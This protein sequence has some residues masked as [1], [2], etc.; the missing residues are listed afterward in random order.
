METDDE[1]IQRLVKEGIAKSE[2]AKADAE[3]IKNKQTSTKSIL[4]FTSNKHTVVSH[5]TNYYGRT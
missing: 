2:K 4:P 1:K 5:E 3:K